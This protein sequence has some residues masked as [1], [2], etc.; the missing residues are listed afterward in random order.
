MVSG[1]LYLKYHLQFCIS[2]YI[3]IGLL[4]LDYNDNNWFSVSEISVTISYSHGLKLE[5]QMRGFFESADYT[6]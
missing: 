4:L 2:S 6:L 3:N 5:W 1:V